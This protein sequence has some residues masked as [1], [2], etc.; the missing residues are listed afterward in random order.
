VSKKLSALRQHDRRWGA[1]QERDKIVRWLTQLKVGGSTDD[2]L[3]TVANWIR[4]EMH[5]DY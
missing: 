5:A 1:S 4:S 2:V 3:R